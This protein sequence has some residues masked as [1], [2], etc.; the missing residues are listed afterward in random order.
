VSALLPYNDEMIGAHATA[1]LGNTSRQKCKG[2]N[3]RLFTATGSNIH[4]SDASESNKLNFFEELQAAE[5][6]KEIEEH[7][8]TIDGDHD[9]L[10]P[11][12]LELFPPLI[13]DNR[14]VPPSALGVL[15]FLP[16][17]TSTENNSHTESDTPLNF[18]IDEF[19]QS[20]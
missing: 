13:S 2:T 17:A 4:P 11:S 10:S 18:N 15:S 19:L 7:C 9:K 6:Q 12:C 5:L 1:Q 14:T 8:H 16:P 20:L 3:K